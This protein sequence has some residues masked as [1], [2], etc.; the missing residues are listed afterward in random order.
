ML[1]QVGLERLTH[2]LLG[3]GIGEPVAAEQ[4]LLPGERQ[5]CDRPGDGEALE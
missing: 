5:P 4:L 1:A 3:R 2:P